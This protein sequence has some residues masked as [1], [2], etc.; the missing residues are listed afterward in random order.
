ML[1][2]RYVIKVT[3]KSGR[4]AGD[5]YFLRKGGYVASGD[6]K[7]EFDYTT[8]SSKG[9]AQRICNHYAADNALNVRIEDQDIERRRAE[10]KPESEFRIYD[11]EVYEPYAV[12]A[13]VTPPTNRSIN[14]IRY[15]SD[16]EIAEMVARGWQIRRRNDSEDIDSMFERLSSSFVDVKIYMTSTRIRGYH[17]YIAL[18]K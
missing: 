15:I 4:N 5:V 8:Y 2:T 13:S 16:S 3:V 12:L 6:L 1:Q 11:D 7:Y 18:V 17:N 9:V 14:K 10:G